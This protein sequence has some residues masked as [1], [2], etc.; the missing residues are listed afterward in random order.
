MTRALIIM[1]VAGSGKT[2]VGRLLARRLGWEFEDA[3]SF[4]PPANIAKME[5]AI[6]LNDDDREPWLGALRALIQG[7]LDQNRSLVLA[8]SALKEKYRRKIAGDDERVRFVYLKGTYALIAK[9]LQSRD[10]HYM[11]ASL[12]DSQFAD[13]EEPDDA[14][15]VHVGE[16]PDELVRRIETQLRDSLPP[17][18]P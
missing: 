12:L 5:Q 9:R 4:H 8:C 10:G 14:I 11:P 18:R 2:T 16:A 3:D 7:R 13:L 1:G 17:T 15:V 6:P